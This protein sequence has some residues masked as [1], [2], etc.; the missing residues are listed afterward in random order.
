MKTINIVK[1]GK[2]YYISTR[3]SGRMV[4]H[5]FCKTKKATEERI[6]AFK[7]EGYSIQ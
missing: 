3:L 5:E 2:G 1:F 6:A 7:K 4:G